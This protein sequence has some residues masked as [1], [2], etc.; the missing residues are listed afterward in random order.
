MSTAWFVICFLVLYIS[1]IGFRKSDRKQN[2]I[3]WCVTSFMVVLCYH[4]LIAGVFNLVNIP[5][6]LWSIGL[7]DILGGVLLIRQI[8]LYGIQLYF[9]RKIDFIVL[10]VLLVLAII[11]SVNQFGADLN[12][13]YASIDATTHFRFALQVMK[14]Q[15]VEGLFFSALNNALFLSLFDPFIKATNLYHLFVLAD[16]IMYYVSGCVFYS[17][18]ADRIDTRYKGGLAIVVTSL[19]MC[20]YPRN[21]MLYGFSYLGMSISLILYLAFVVKCYLNKEF[22]R[23]FVVFAL[24]SGC[25]ALGVC[26]SL[27]I[28]VVYVSVCMA[29]S[30]G[31]WMEKDVEIKYKI[32][33]I[34]LENLKIFV[35]PCFLAL[36]Y[37]FIGFF[38]PAGSGNSIST[39]ISAEGGIY[40][41]LFSNFIFWIPFTLYG[42]YML[43]KKRKNNL[44]AYYFVLIIL[45]MLV[46]G[47]AGM[48]GYVSSYYFYKNHFFLSAVVFYLS[49]VGICYLMEKNC[50]YVLINIGV[51]LALGLTSILGIEEKIQKRN[52]LF[53]PVVKSQYYFDIYVTNNIILDNQED[54]S[55]EKMKLY[56]YCF[57]NFPIDKNDKVVVCSTLYDLNVFRAV[58]QRIDDEDFVFWKYLSEEEQAEGMKEEIDIE[59]YVEAY[60]D[61][62]G[63]EDTIP[64][65][66]LD[67][68]GELIDELDNLQGINVEVEYKNSQGAVGT[69]KYN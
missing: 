33:K 2:V 63:N 45:F 12:L 17:V 43:I 66:V 69:L 48:K 23:R 61:K 56:E 52:F 26:Y 5:I 50:K 49:F 39:G 58:T 59:A 1:L 62:E 51:F 60:R 55:Q 34:I 9:C 68:A 53:V 13:N 21:N 28:P 44:M 19:Y 41:D 10:S 36:I 16:I 6:N 35:L 7:A 14:T 31:I 30:L 64:F 4:V 37:S 11:G 20:G 8:K 38:G 24:M 15:K 18:I 3:V 46:L 29:I 25:A 27:F 67:D 54:Y 32:K 65:L 40:R 47:I 42:W 57:D 22:K